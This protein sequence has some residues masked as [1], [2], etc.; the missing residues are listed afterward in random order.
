MY[1]LMPT[2]VTFASSIVI[3]ANGRAVQ[4]FKLSSRDMIAATAFTVLVELNNFFY[5]CS[6]PLAGHGD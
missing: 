5:V 4:E 2:V 1:G 3:A 6:C